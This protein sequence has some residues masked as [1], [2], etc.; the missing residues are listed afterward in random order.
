MWQGRRTGQVS[1]LLHSLFDNNLS[2]WQYHQLNKIK[3]CFYLNNKRQICKN[4]LLYVRRLYS[5]RSSFTTTSALP[6]SAELHS[7]VFIQTQWN[8]TAPPVDVSGTT[9]TTI[10]CQWR[11]SKFLAFIWGF[12]LYETRASSHSI[13]AKGKFALKGIF[14]TGLSHWLSKSRD[15]RHAFL[16]VCCL[17]D[18][19]HSLLF[20]V[21]TLIESFFGCSI[22]HHHFWWVPYRFI[23]SQT[24]Q[25]S[26]SGSPIHRDSHEKLKAQ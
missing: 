6:E 22:W 25:F 24:L 13:R 1:R 21:Y 20:P 11:L 9:S 5:V 17:S 16:I 4:A 10:T 14:E 15:R 3:S 2:P 18:L 19:L 26:L 23:F 8:P 7:L 12:R